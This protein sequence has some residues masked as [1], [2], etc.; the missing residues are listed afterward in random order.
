MRDRTKASTPKMQLSKALSIK[1]MFSITYKI[2]DSCWVSCRLMDN[3]KV[4]EISAT[5]I[6]DPLGHLTLGAASLLSGF[7][8][9]S[10][11]FLEEPGEYRWNITQSENGLVNIEILKYEDN[12]E[13]NSPKNRKLICSI[14]CKLVEFGRAVNDICCNVL[15]EIGEEEYNQIWDFDRFPREA[16]SILKGRL[17]ELDLLHS[18]NCE[19]NA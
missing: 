12:F 16:F 17:K 9:V 18:S 6:G 5:D 14:N 2:I 19:N 10:F 1:N 4:F 15:S 8:Q 13:I 3:D 11:S 7:N